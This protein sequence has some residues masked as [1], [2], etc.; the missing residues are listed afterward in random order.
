MNMKKI[1]S[2][3]TITVIFGIIIAFCFI[4]PTFASDLKVNDD[5][6]V[7]TILKP[8]QVIGKVNN[9]YLEVTFEYTD[10]SGYKNSFYY[11]S[12][13]GQDFVVPNIEEAEQLDEYSQHDIPKK[14][15]YGND[16][17]G[18]KIT[19]SYEIY[20]N[21]RKSITL[22]PYYKNKYEITKQPTQEDT[23]VEVNYPENVQ[24]YTWYKETKVKNAKS[25]LDR[26]EVLNSNNI[27]TY[28]NQQNTNENSLWKYSTEDNIWS[29]TGLDTAY[30][31]GYF[32]V[33]NNEDDMNIIIKLD[34]TSTANGYFVINI[35]DMNNNL[36]YQTSKSIS[37]YYSGQDMTFNLKYLKSNSTYKFLIEYDNN[38]YQEDENDYIKLKFNNIDVY[39]LDNVEVI[40]NQNKST[41]ESDMIDETKLYK[42]DI[43]YKDN[44][45]LSS[46]LFS[47]KKIAQNTNTIDNKKQ[48]SDETN[49]LTIDNIY[50]Y[51]SILL[52]STITIIF[53]TKKLKKT[54]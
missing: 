34:Q 46:N 20:C 47:A 18:W 44:S 14:D 21:V 1:I 27:V 54:K 35:Y 4:I 7:G 49:P 45:K 50:L 25:T 5:L 36:V 19:S 33:S 3:K 41:L 10:E 31:Y 29:K 39:T 13:S 2:S 30:L 16:F 11:N 22:E 42:V 38:I 8:G 52:I 6:P 15:Q 48:D 43:L 12:T 9:V 17:V 28:S 23:T 53:A 51:I 26:N 40:Q 32:D 37:G 24:S